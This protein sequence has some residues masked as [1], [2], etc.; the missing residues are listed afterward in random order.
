MIHVLFNLV[1]RFGLQAE[2]ALYFAGA[3]SGRQ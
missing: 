1:W 3:T 2:M